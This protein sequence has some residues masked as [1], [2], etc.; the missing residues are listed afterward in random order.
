MVYRRD[1]IP[2]KNDRAL[3][4]SLTHVHGAIYIASD[5]VQA[6]EQPSKAR[7]H[8]GCADDHTIERYTEAVYATVAR[9][10]EDMKAFEGRLH[11]QA[12]VS[13]CFTSCAMHQVADHVRTEVASRGQQCWRPLE[14]CLPDCRVFVAGDLSGSLPLVWADAHLAF[15]YFLSLQRWRAGTMQHLPACSRH[16][17]G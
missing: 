13:V 11:C 6:G 16:V 12:L 4:H 7:A 1:P 2:G 3:V 5:Q 9:H 14:T 8:G 15:Q 17:S 10:F